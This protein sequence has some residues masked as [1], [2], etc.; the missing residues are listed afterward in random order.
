MKSGIA[1]GANM[2]RGAHRR[3]LFAMAVVLKGGIIAYRASRTAHHRVC[4]S[5]KQPA[6]EIE[7][8]ARLHVP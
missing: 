3:A 4:I 1:K 5:F 6:R 8:L 2:V 7:P